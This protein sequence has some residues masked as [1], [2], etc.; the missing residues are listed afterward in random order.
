MGEGPGRSQEQTPG[1]EIEPGGMLPMT[2]GNWD[3]VEKL[4]RI[5][6]Q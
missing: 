1:G 2:S 4:T 5:V 3:Q 6:W